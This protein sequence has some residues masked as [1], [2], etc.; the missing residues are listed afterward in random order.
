[1]HDHNI[2]KQQDAFSYTSN[3]RV[4][5]SEVYQMSLFFNERLVSTVN[6]GDVGEEVEHTAGVTPLVVVPGDE[7]DEVVVERDAGLG[8]EDG[9]CFVA[10]E[11][12]GD[13]VVLGVCKD[14]CARKS[15]CVFGPSLSCITYP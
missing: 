1:M 6:L 3:P 13:D 14:A 8:V 12:A 9:G 2:A 15:A 4:S 5:L 7:L 11:V 10:V